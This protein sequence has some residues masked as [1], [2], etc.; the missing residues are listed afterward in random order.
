MMGHFLS[1]RPNIM[2]TG[3]SIRNV[4]LS[5][6]KRPNIMNYYK[7]N[8]V[9]KMT[10][11]ILLFTYLLTSSQLKK[12]LYFTPQN[13]LNPK[14]SSRLSIPKSHFLAFPLDQVSRVQEFSRDQI[15]QSIGET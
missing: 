15:Y 5:S 13:F 3:H 10:H 8:E 2:L 11:L 9:T 12:N 4:S 1:K 7:I 14:I 6:I